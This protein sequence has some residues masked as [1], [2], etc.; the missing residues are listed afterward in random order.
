MRGEHSPEPVGEQQG[1]NQ[2]EQEERSASREERIERL[3]ELV[4]TKVGLPLI[5]ER[6][7]SDEEEAEFRSW[8]KSLSDDRLEEAIQEED[9]RV[10][11]DVRNQW[12]RGIVHP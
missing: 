6:D 12:P 9:E 2:S 10:D 8:A 1:T 5:Y 11:R 4:A 3:R 7:L